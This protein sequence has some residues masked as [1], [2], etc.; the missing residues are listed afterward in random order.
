MLRKYLRQ[1]E[2]ERR[3]DTYR[4]YA[5]LLS[6]FDN[7]LRKQNKSIEN[8]E[9]EDIV[10]YLKKKDNWTKKTGETF[11]TIV[12]TFLRWYLRKIPNPTTIPE[13][14]NYNMIRNRIEDILDLRY[15]TSIEKI[16]RE[17]K[18][19]AL[20]IDEVKRLLKILKKRSREDYLFTYILLYLGLR[21]TEL[22]GIGKRTEIDLRKNKLKVLIAK[23]EYGIRTLYFN[24]YVKRLLKEYLK[25]PV[26]DPWVFNNKLKRYSR[27]MGF[28]VYPHMLRNT[29][30]T[31]QIK[32]I[33][34]EVL[35]DR[36]MGHAPKSMGEHYTKISDEE[37]KEA[38]TTLH[39]MKNIR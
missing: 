20:T 17:K 30:R 14:R 36:L 34:R 25:N 9:R 24:N 21:K 11:L 29:F 28:R 3:K 15:P 1:I 26:R 5:V 37:I 23:T 13:L 8:C 38:M 16:P 7:W 32:R 18:K 2:A 39:Y 10:A 27:I 31:A 12:K 33:G 19:E 35:V 4:T 22:L 6:S